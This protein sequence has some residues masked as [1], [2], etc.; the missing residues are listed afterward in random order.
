MKK[1]IIYII[2]LYNLSREVKIIN[3]VQFKNKLYFK[4][5]KKLTVREH[6]KIQL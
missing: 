1:N 4:E 3:E 5:S 2:I 6:S